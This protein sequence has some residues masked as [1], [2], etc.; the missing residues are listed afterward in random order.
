MTVLRS[1]TRQN[2]LLTL[3]HS[4]FKSNSQYVFQ[5]NLLCAVEIKKQGHWR[6]ECTKYLTLQVYQPYT[7][8]IIQAETLPVSEAAETPADCPCFI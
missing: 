2:P 8:T 4:L 1:P 6:G 5:H 7:G 3:F